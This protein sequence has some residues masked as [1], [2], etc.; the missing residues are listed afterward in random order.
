M[1]KFQTIRA[2]ETKIDS[3][4][5]PAGLKNPFWSKAATLAQDRQAEA[6]AQRERQRRHF[7]Q[8]G[9][10]LRVAAGLERDDEGQRAFVEARILQHGIDVQLMSMRGSRPGPR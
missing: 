2:A 9:M 8:R 6:R 3:A 1:R 4:F 10:Q 7:L 5:A